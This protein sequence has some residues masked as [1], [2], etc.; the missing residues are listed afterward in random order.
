MNF[1][2]LR[3]WLFL[4]QR[5]KTL[6]SW[7][8][9]N[10]IVSVAIYGLGA[11]GELLEEELSQAGFLPIYGIDQDA[12]KIGKRDFPVY[13]TTLKNYPKVDAIIVTTVSIYWDIVGLL[14]GKTNAPFVSLEDV[15]SYCL[16]MEES[17]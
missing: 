15:I 9:D 13:D 12:S 4:R 16:S 5:G 6:L 11:M 7:F 8:E 2:I 1:H 14:G 3:D 17:K 10:L